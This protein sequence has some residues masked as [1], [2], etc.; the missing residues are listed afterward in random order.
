MFFWSHSKFILITL[1]VVYLSLLRSLCSYS[2]MSSAFTK[3]PFNLLHREHMLCQRGT[4][5]TKMIDLAGEIYIYIFWTLRLCLK[6]LLYLM[7]TTLR[8][9]SSFTSCDM[10]DAFA[11]RHVF[12]SCHCFAYVT[13][14]WRDCLSCHTE[15]P[16]SSKSVLHTPVYSDFPSWLVL[17]FQPRLS[18]SHLLTPA[19][20]QR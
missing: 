11:S 14:R 9:N 17:V 18:L 10:K 2:T 1:C 20:A 8:C 12:P 5:L 13:F 4:Y 15:A 3:N 16:L 6:T 19:P 7:S